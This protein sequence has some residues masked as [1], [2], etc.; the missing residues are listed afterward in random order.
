MQTKQQNRKE[1]PTL[2]QWVDFLGKSN[3]VNVRE[4]KNRGE[5]IATMYGFS[6]K[7]TMETMEID[8]TEARK[9]VGR[10]D[11][12]SFKELM[13]MV[14]DAIKPKDPTKKDLINSMTAAIAA[15]VGYCIDTAFSI[16]CSAHF[17][18]AEG[19]HNT[20]GGPNILTAELLDRASVAAEWI[21]FFYCG[22]G[23]LLTLEND[24]VTVFRQSAGEV[25]SYKEVPG[26]RSFLAER[27]GEDSALFIHGKSA[28][29]PA[30]AAK[31]RAIFAREI[32]EAIIRKG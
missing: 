13:D 22:N 27:R 16:R 7:H 23:R 28:K 24:T 31:F 3:G 32:A 4:I 18:A 10:T 8:E 5:F 17:N 12:G 25:P 21:D 14:F 30:S 6:V 15:G 9:Y 19:R 1:L 29:K 11:G 2:I 20:T 26:V